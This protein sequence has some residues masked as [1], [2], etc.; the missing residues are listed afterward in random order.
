MFTDNVALV[1]C[2]LTV[3]SAKTFTAPSASKK[4]NYTKH[5]LPYSFLGLN[6]A[7]INKGRVAYC[8]KTCHQK[9][10]SLSGIKISPGKYDG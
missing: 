2:C 9:T 5:A 3:V 4:N 1:Q 7:T 6:Q 10:D 8:R